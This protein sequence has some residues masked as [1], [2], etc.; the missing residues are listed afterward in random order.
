[1]VFLLLIVIL[2]YGNKKKKK[3]KKKL[4]CE[5]VLWVFKLIELL[6]FF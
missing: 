3:K 6:D 4:D 2:Y 5:K 1:M